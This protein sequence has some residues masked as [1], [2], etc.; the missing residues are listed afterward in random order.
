ML[1][2]LMHLFGRVV[3]AFFWRHANATGTSSNANVGREAD[4]RLVHIFPAT[5]EQ[6][7]ADLRRIGMLEAALA[8]EP[9]RASEHGE[10]ASLREAHARLIRAAKASGDFIPADRLA[11]YGERKRRPSSESEVYFDPERNLYAKVK[12]PAAKAYIKRTTPD[13]WPYEHII[14]NIFFPASRYEFQGVS[15]RLGEAR[16][17]LTQRAIDAETRASDSL[18]AATLA[19]KG[20]FLED[21]FFFGNDLVA[22]TDVGQGG[23]NALVADDGSIAFIDPLIRLKRPA[24]EILRVLLGE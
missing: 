19:E 7:M 15:E 20:F 4:N 14:H 17:V 13:D 24:R 1:E 16:I 12:D 22:V 23:D 11:F 2:S 9:L 21:R 18:V 10:G 3:N 5:R 6:A 8:A